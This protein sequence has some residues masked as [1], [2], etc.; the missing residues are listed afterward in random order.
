MPNRIMTAQIEPPT[1]LMI[2]LV[3]LI[4]TFGSNPLRTM[5]NKPAATISPHNQ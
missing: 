5:A 3:R 4:G 1:T 2:R